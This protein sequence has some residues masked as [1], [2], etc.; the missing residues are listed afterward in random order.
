MA[1][2][3]VMEFYL[4]LLESSLSGFQ[5]NLVQRLDGVRYAGVDIQG[6]VDHSIGADTK[7]ASELETVPKYLS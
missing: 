7:D 5:T 6:T 3:P 2:G 4:A 1:A